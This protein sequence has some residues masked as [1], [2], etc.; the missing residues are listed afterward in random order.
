MKLEELIFLEGNWEGSGTARYPSLAEVPYTEILSFEY[1]STKDVIFYIQRTKFNLPGKEK[2]TLHIESGF[3]KLTDSGAV[4]LS[5][6]QNNGRVE[7]LTLKEL[8]C[9]SILNK[10]V[11]ESKLFGN[12]PRMIRTSREYTVT[13]KSLLY[14]MKMATQSNS[15]LSTHLKAELQKK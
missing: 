8:S 11:F 2:D 15:S 6:S 4:E 3:I 7:V 14:E 12:D 10:A 13:G 9:T 5:N 1:D